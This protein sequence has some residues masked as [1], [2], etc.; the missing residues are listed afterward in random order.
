MPVTETRI[1][2]SLGLIRVG[3]GRSSIATELTAFRTKLGFSCRPVASQIT[4]YLPT[5]H[6]ILQLTILGVLMC[7]LPWL[8]LT[9]W[10]QL[11][12]YHFLQDGYGAEVF[13]QPA[14][15]PALPVIWLPDAANSPRDPRTDGLEFR[16]MWSIYRLI[17]ESS[18]VAS[19]LKYR[20]EES[21]RLPVLSPTEVGIPNLCICG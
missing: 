11:P 14:A 18:S 2:T 4:S 20:R 13:I 8:K 10:K 7:W 15:A 17:G 21:R 19:T 1:R 12:F 6:G 9:R 16:L 3:I 5:C